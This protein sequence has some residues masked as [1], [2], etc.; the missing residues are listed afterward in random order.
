M[1]II[2]YWLLGKMLPENGELEMET[3]VMRHCEYGRHKNQR[4]V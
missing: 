3:Y 4:D 1:Q 2:I